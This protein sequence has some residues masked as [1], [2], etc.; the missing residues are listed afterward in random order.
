MNNAV[1]TFDASLDTMVRAWLHAKRGRT[2]SEATE[3]RY[4]ATLA[5]FRALL[6]T[7][8]IDLDGDTALVAT[9]AQGWAAS[10]RTGARTGARTGEGVAP[11]TF[12]QRVN[13]LSSF[14]RYV[15]RQGLFVDTQG[16]AR[17]NPIDRIDR[18]QAQAY[19]NARALPSTLVRERLAAIETD[20][21]LGMRDAALLWLT[22]T[23]GRRLS[24]VAGIRRE[25][26][27]LDGDTLVITFPHAK[28][29]KVLRDA[30]DARVAAIL[31]LYLRTLDVEMPT[32]E[33]SAV[34]VAIGPHGRGKA[35]HKRSLERICEQRLGTS[36]FHALRHTFAHAMED[37]G[38]KISEI[39]A[40]LGHS[41][42]A[43]T[44]VYLARL[45]SEKNPYAGAIA[46]LF[47]D[48]PTA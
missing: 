45:S 8:G 28:G 1:V 32:H 27:S 33:S 4:A 37:L 47:R 46:A 2:N 14:Y 6:H 20:T 11:A 29:G 35:L 48:E 3:Q 18:R 16:N 21:L 31:A 12:N 23:T 24:E 39:Q 40:R 42:I 13:V 41:S 7:Q 26:M 10:S 34:W 15:I 17:A 44:G 38:A 5:T 22:L 25:H 43:V 30:L 36:H 9:L 19:A